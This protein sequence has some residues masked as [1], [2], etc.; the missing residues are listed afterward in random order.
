ML[1]GLLNVASHNLNRQIE[2]VFVFEIGKTYQSQTKGFPKEQWRL[3]ALAVGSP[4]MSAMDKGRVDYFYMKGIL[5]NLLN[6][7]GISNYRFIETTNHLLQ[8]GRGA[9]IP[10]LGI[11]GEVHPDIRR[12][13]AIE[14]P[15]CFFDIDLDALFKLASAEKKYQPLPKF[16]SVSRDI[17]MFVPQGIEHQMIVS[18]VRKI[19]G[20]LV[21]GIYLFDKYKDSL[22]YRV[23]YRS[24]KKTLTD[25]EVNNKHQEI[26]G[27]LE[28]KLSVRVRK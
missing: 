16:P 2:N 24:P 27:A 22:A 10:G 18:I 3:C 4:F 25:S 8:P 19:G 20:D 15:A 14:N 7:L 17:S 5:E 13:Y 26:L 28:S 11:Q 1:P 23:I 6:A 9:E 21:E 12:N